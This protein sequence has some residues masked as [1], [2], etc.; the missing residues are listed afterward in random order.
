M[1]AG[2]CTSVTGEN[3]LGREKMVKDS[4]PREAKNDG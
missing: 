4:D 3:R 1:L 2:L